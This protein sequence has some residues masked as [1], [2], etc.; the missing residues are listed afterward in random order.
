MP[1]PLLALIV[2]TLLVMSGC[3]SVNLNPTTWETPPLFLSGNA[4]VGSPAWWKK[5]KSKAEFVPGEGYRV[6]DVEGYFD[7][8]GRPIQAKVAKTVKQDG[9]KGLLKDVNV[10]AAVADI[11]SQVG[12]GPDEQQAKLAFA[13]GEDLFQREKY[14]AAAKQF[15]QTIARWPDSILAQDAMFLMAESYFFSH[16]YADAVDIYDRLIKENASSKHLDKVIRRQFDIARY[17]EEHHQHEPHYATTP[18]LFDD[19]RQFFDTLG[20]ALKVYE[21][22]RLNDPTGPLADDAIMATGNSFFLRGRYRDADYNYELIRTEYPQSEHQFEAHILGLQCKLQKYQGPDYDGAPLLEAKRLVKQIKVQFAGKLDE[23]ERARLA[24]DEAALQKQ[25]ATRELKRAKFYEENGH[26][27]SAK[28][29][30]AKI[31]RLFPNTPIAN[32]A[33]QQYV[34]LEGKPDSPP[35]LMADVIK[36]LPDNAERE[37]VKQVPLLESQSEILMARPPA[38]SGDNSQILR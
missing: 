35:V 5:Q 31:Q 27:A 14:P 8:E 21:N 38:A 1:K 25:L 37:A 23:Q 28:F 36:L 32:E 7:Q 10:T 9:P 30:Y 16:D 6:A 33:Q 11:K 29:Y 19:T 4:P 34:A 2:V 3:A 15:K 26:N 20:R 12:L 13:K 17:W 18:N 24:I 22:I